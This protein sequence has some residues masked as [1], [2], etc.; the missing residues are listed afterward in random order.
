MNRRH[1]ILA[2]AATTLLSK[3]AFATGVAQTGSATET[4]PSARTLAQ[5]P[6]RPQYHLLPQAGFVGDPCAPRFFGGHYHVFFHG[7]FGGRGWH[8]AVSSDLVHWRH[9]P[10]AL[11]P[12]D[13]GYDSYG[14]F[15]GGVMP[16]EEGASIVYTGVTKVGRNAETIRAEGLREAQC[17]AVSTDPML[18]EFKKLPSPAIAGPPPRLE[19]TGFRDPFGWKDG[20]TWYMGVGSGFPQVGGAVL[21]YRSIDML[22]WEYVHP[23][24]QGVWNG[25]SFSNPVPSGEMWECPDF[26][27]LGDRDVLI[28][29]TEHTTFWEVGVFDRKALRFNSESRGILDH[30]AYYAPRSMPDGNGRRILWGWVQETRPS[31]ESQE[32][33]WA[34]CISLPRILTLGADRKLRIEVAPELAALQQA[35][36][37]LVAPSPVS[38]AAGVKLGVARERAGKVVCRFNPSPAPCSLELRLP[39]P[40]G[41]TSLFKVNFSHANGKPVAAIGDRLLVLSPSPDQQST[42]EIWLDGSVVET[43]LDKRQAITSRCYE[44]TNAAGEIEAWWSGAPGQLKDFS[45]FQLKA[46]SP[47]RLTT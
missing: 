43:Y 47:D 31:S 15:T 21:L 3:A 10:I 26:F 17:I 5:D 35:D 24:A 45:V 29:S 7:S 38:S 27:Q 40:S 34:G 14:T 20:N 13:G 28:Y 37:S 44:A 42:I 39:A 16:G 33:G 11:S 1:F 18:R 6:L 32:A 4:L 2:S 25:Q 9:M 22:H 30:G 19:I 23:L 41:N 8:H 36:I 46:V 12:T